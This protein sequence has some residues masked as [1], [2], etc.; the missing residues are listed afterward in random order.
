VYTAAKREDRIRW[1][2]LTLVAIF[3]VGALYTHYTIQ[4][5]ANVPFP[6]LPAG[7]AGLILLWR[8]RDRIT[9]AAFGGFV[10]VILLYLVSILVA[11]DIRFLPRR[12]NGLIQITYS[13]TIGFALF[14]TVAHA[15]PR[16]MAA[17]FLGLALVI[18]VGCLLEVYGGLRQLSDQVRNAI[19]TSGIYEDDLRD[20]L[21]Y[22]RARPKFFASEPSS[23]TF[24]YTLFAFL[25]LVLSRWRWKLVFYVGLVGLGLVAMP[26]PTI[27]LM[28]VLLLPYMLFLESRRAGRLDGRRVVM[29]SCI[30]VVLTGAF[31]ILAQ[32]QF[33]E[34][35]NAA[36]AGDDPSF[37]Y[38]IQ[39]PALAAFEI[40]P[41]YPIGGGGLAAELF[42]QRQIT[43]VY[44]RSPSYSAHWRV[45]SPTT[46]LVINYFW[47]H[48]I[49]LG[50][51]W[52]VIMIAALTVWLRLLDVP[53]PAFCWTVW[54][55]L[56]QASG[57]YVG[58]T[59][60]A[61][62]FLAGAAAILHQR[63]APALP[64]LPPALPLVARARGGDVPASQPLPAGH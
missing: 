51:V 19:Y 15:S 39:G 57:A 9:P 18:A 64:T 16:Q 25:W 24:C 55:I 37:F 8:R 56:G 30:A 12:A 29:F 59:C 7:I 32:V 52:G 41:D 5:A 43:N 54:A 10:A 35:V 20:V 61:V 58:P 34:R 48:W 17:L 47:E 44:L 38:R 11:A 22:K 1:L 33:R 2:D 42:L 23:V 3:L 13:L 31:L 27:L 21:F 60:W 45:I 36:L 63:H 46:E 28:L 49:Y 4:V 40:I 62:L 26:G 53:S 50:F 14:L 6:S